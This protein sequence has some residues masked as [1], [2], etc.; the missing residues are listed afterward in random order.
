MSM[1]AVF[2]AFAASA[3]P[4]GWDEEDDIYYNPSKKKP[5]KQE[6]SNYVP[7]T[8][9]DY[10]GADTYIPSTSG[11]NMDV[12][13]YNRN[14]N[15]LIGDTVAGD[16]S[17]TNDSFAY[18]RRIEQFHDSDI[19]TASGDQELVDYYYSSSQPSEINIYITDPYYGFRPYYRSYYNPWYWNNYYWDSY[20]WNYGFYDPW[21]NRT[22]GWSWTWGPS[23]YPAPMPPMHGPG[24]G[25]A[26]GYGGNS[27][28]VNPSGAMNTHRPASG[29]SSVRRPGEFS[30]GA[31]AI[32]NRPGSGSNN[33]PSTVTPSTNSNKP[34]STVG[35]RGR[36]NS[37]NDNNNDKNSYNSSRRNSSSSGS[38]G[39][40]SRSSGRSSGG[41]GGTHRSTGGGGGR[42]RR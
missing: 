4:A 22:W 16:S 7:N 42:G 37:R 15:F 9:I 21:Y 20:Y 32:T 24:W 17:R 38:I 30:A 18:T 36:N 34:N 2:T 3:S 23:W 13:A 35:N 28:A 25:P 14:G 19:V 29:S 8:V 41:S 5:A 31:S 6:N 26:P 11:L 39:S 33:R 27:A 12:D 1:L 10:P 40:S